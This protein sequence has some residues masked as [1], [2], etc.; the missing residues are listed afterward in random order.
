[1]DPTP[2]S[3]TKQTAW[4]SI[5]NLA[6]NID[7]FNVEITG[8]VFDFDRNNKKY[9]HYIMRCTYGK[10]IRWEVRRRYRQFEKLAELLSLGYINI[11]KLPGKTL[12]PVVDD[13]KVEKRREGLQ[14]FITP[15][16][17]REDLFSH[18][19]FCNF[20][21]IPLNIPFM[22]MNTPVQI[23]QIVNGR[24]F[25]YRDIV[26]DREWE[27]ALGVSHEY[28]VTGRVDSYFTN[29]FSPKKLPSQ[30]SEVTKLTEKPVGVLDILIR[31]DK[32]FNLSP[33]NRMDSP[34]KGYTLPE[35]S[36]EDGDREPRSPDSVSSRLR[37][38][39]QEEDALGY[40]NYVRSAERAYKFQAICIA[41]DKDMEIVAVGLDS[42]DIFVYGYSHPD[43]SSFNSETPYLKA[44]DKRVMSI[45]FDGNTKRMYSV[46]EDKKLVSSDLLGKSVIGKV[47]MPGGKPTNMVYCP[48]LSLCAVSDK[49]GG[50]YIADLSHTIPEISMKIVT[51]L[52]GPIRG[53]DA[54]LE[55]GIVIASSHADG[56]IR[57]FR[58]SSLP[59]RAGHFTCVLIIQSTPGIRCL[60]YW[61]ERQE[62]WTGYEYGGV[63]VHGGIDLLSPGILKEE[64]NSVR[65]TCTCTHGINQ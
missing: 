7:L 31:A 8:Y 61:P 41:A 26:I 19:Y 38:R 45:S 10:N 50:I 36:G 58:N 62:I 13:K 5:P 12:L 42:G 17:H 6:R 18:P 29:L 59:Q 52:K 35:D 28:Y 23:G 63:T 60:R 49:D 57:V 56:G 39:G 53:M 46:G 32:T 3:P 4:T 1:M 14:D 47:N 20:F 2:L 30:Q 11:P 48:A 21:S 24:G 65:T 43:I 55:Q 34:G 33:V 40:F 15:L 54:I 51:L 25:A 16:L 9:A 27:Y 44:H 37:D 64:A 22:Q